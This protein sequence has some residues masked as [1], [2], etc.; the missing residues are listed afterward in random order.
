MSRPN[1]AGKPVMVDRSDT[2]GAVRRGGPS[3]V[4]SFDDGPTAQDVDLSGEGPRRLRPRDVPQFRGG[5]RGRRR[6]RP[7]R[8]RH[9]SR[10]WPRPSTR[11]S[12]APRPTL[13]STRPT[14]RPN[15]QDATAVS[16]FVE[17]QCAQVGAPA[18]ESFRCGAG[19]RG[20]RWWCRRSIVTFGRRRAPG[21]GTR[22]FYDPARG[23]GRSV[24]FERRSWPTNALRE[25]I[26][27]PARVRPRRSAAFFQGSSGR[28]S[29]RTPRE[30]P[31]RLSARFARDR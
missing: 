24:R 15:R 19:S 21:A 22:R 9:A 26:A 3:R 18:S 25:P 1:S 14:P 10:R 4:D 17:N 7:S 23:I 28:R 2:R 6:D 16:I 8:A 30:G 31:N 13:A 29:S 11:Q 12:P 20:S 5:R 27:T